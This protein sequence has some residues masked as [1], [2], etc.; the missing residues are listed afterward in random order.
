VAVSL[1]TSTGNIPRRGMVRGRSI[2]FN[3]G[4]RHHDLSVAI[5]D[6]LGPSGYC[7]VVVVIIVGVGGRG[8]TTG[9][10][11]RRHARVVLF[12][13]DQVGRRRRR[14]RKRRRASRIHGLAE[15]STLCR[16]SHDKQRPLRLLH[17]PDPR[18]MPPPP[19]VV[20]FVVLLPFIPPPPLPTFMLLLLRWRRIILLRRL[21]PLSDDG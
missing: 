10:Q 9:Q 4:R 15:W 3:F 7:R 11:C 17:H 21:L 14:R 8:P 18:S 2:C 13:V 5:I 20:V 16:R 19:A 1:F 6:P 12:Q